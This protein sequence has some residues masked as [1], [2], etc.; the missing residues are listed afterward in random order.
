MS[1][2]DFNKRIIQKL[3]IKTEQNETIQIKINWSL[4]ERLRAYWLINGPNTDQQCREH[5]KRVRIQSTVHP[6]WWIGDTPIQKDEGNTHQASNQASIHVRVWTHWTHLWDLERW[7]QWTLQYVQ[8]MDVRLNAC[9][10]NRFTGQIVTTTTIIGDWVYYLKNGREFSKPKTVFI[11]TYKQC[12]T[13]K[14]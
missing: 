5:F 13:T 11:T 10:Y 1:I 6:T 7:I 3:P 2:E 12:Q 8:K 14:N 9:Y 4:L